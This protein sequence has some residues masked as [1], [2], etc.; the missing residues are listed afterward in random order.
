MNCSSASW[1]NVKRRMR[2]ALGLLDQAAGG[3]DMP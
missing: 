3:Q 1:P 2:H